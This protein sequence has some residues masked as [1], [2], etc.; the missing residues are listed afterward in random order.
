MVKGE[1]AGCGCD[2][3]DSGEAM[4]FLGDGDIKCADDDPDDSGDGPH[5]IFSFDLN[6]NLNLRIFK[7]IRIIICDSFFLNLTYIETSEKFLSTLGTRSIELELHSLLI[8]DVVGDAEPI[9]G[10]PGVIVKLP[11]LV[12]DALEAF[13]SLPG[14]GAANES[15]RILLLLLI[16]I[17]CCCGCPAFACCCCC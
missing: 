10:N 9:C 6:L 7:P 17:C 14:D 8:I 2:G 16:R 4:T 12:D 5:L 11:K 15:R 3:L 13:E 1:S